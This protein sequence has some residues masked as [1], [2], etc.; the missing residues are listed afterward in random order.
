[1]LNE[2]WLDEHKQQFAIDAVCLTALSVVLISE[3]ASTGLAINARCGVN[4]YV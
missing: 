3:G 2:D 1:M 4:P